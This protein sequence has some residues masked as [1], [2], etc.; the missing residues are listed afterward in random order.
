MNMSHSTLKQLLKE[1]E[2]K[3][4]FAL[5]DLENRKE[6]LYRSCPR[7]QEIDTNLNQF[8]FHTVKSILSSTNKSSSLEDLK[9][10]IAS[11]KLEKN[12]ILKDLKLDDSFFLPHFD[13]TKC[14]DTGY[15]KENDHYELC[16]C[17][18]QKLFD[19]DYNQSNISNLRNH[20]FDQ[21]L[22]DAYSTQI[23]ED[24]YHSNLSPRDNIQNIKEIAFSFITHF[25]DFEEKNLL[26][27]GNTG[28]R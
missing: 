28:L 22:L 25:D 18:K 11:L 17:I 4:S 27:T 3:R 2:Q 23:N 14:E 1:Y 20:T 26:F 13:C 15:V 16:S 9:S 7:L 8:A 12:A 24:L 21:F 19:M 5:S 10:K 6:E